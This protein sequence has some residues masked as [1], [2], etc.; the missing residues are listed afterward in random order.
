MIET[1]YGQILEI[2]AAASAVVIECAGVG[3]RVTVTSRALSSLPLP[4]FAPD[5]TRLDS[6]PV[7]IWTHLALREDAA[8]LYGFADREEL[9]MYRLLLSVSGVG[10]K[11][12]M[13]IL[14]LLPPKKLAF[15]VAN[16]DTKAIAKAPGVGEK[17]AAMVI[18]KLKDKIPKQFP[19]FFAG[20]A[21]GEDG[22]TPAPKK[23][24]GSGAMADAR[25]ALAALGYS[26]SEIAAALKTADEGAEAD[27]IIRA[28]LAYLLKN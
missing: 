10:P 27:A 17:T 15:A 3:F 28:A 21:R 4:A 18:L 6:P 20:N 11:A 22:E 19:Q 23:K 2:N 12:G 1:L 8:D 7:R 24:D 5:G 13:S 16:G 9:T 25:D 26:R 14:S